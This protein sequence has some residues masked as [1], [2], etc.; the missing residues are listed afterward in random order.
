MLSL[1]DARVAYVIDDFSVVLNLGRE[2]VEEGMRFL[3]YGLSTDEILDPV[4]QNSL[5]HLEIVRGTGIVTYVQDAMCILTSDK[6]QKGIISA[7][8][9]M[10]G[11]SDSLP[12]NSPEVGDFAR[13]I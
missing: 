3:V 4:T 2:I 13:L 6:K 11:E 10:I 5:G 1:K 9:L 8:K 12:F 7:Q